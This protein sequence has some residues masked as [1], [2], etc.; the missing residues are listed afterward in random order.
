MK[1]AIIFAIIAISI[2]VAHLNNAQHW[3]PPHIAYT[4][5]FLQHYPGRLENALAL[6]PAIEKLSSDYGIEPLV[7]V[8]TIASESSFRS[9]V[10]GFEKREIGLMQVHGI[11]A[12]GE[13]MTSAKGQ[14]EAGIKCLAMA[15]DAC[16]GSTR[17]MLTMY[18]SG[19]CKPRTKR[20][21]NLIRRRM[22]I[23]E[24]WSDE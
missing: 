1:R 13:D 23:I 17:Q 9:N 7:V 6:M 10:I 5:H 11:C 3:K 22:L 8:V 24:K 15:R 19:S 2:T 16:D 21:A 14:L 20:T 18:A 12:R 4:E